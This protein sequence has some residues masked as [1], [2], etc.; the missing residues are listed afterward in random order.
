[1]GGCGGGWCGSQNLSCV[2]SL[3]SIHSRCAARA[4]CHIITFKKP[5]YVSCFVSSSC[6]GMGNWACAVTA[7]LEAW[8]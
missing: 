3:V 8:C 7:A 6:L 1:M 4:Q 5:S 2:A